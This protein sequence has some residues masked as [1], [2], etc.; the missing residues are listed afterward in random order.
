MS[1]PLQVDPED[2][3]RRLNSVITSYNDAIAALSERGPEIEPASLGEGFVAEGEMLASAAESIHELTLQRLRARVSQ[4]ESM[5]TLVDDV[6][7]T[8]ELNAGRLASHG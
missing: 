3:R 7:A 6:A 5:L 1:I 2:F 8:D 4:F